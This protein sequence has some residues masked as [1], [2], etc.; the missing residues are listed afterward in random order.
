MSLYSC[1]SSEK[2]LR[3]GYWEHKPTRPEKSGGNADFQEAF[4]Q[5]EL[6]FLGFTKNTIPLL[7]G[8]PLGAGRAV[9][10][11]PPRRGAGA[12]HNTTL[13]GESASLSWNIPPRGWARVKG[14]GPLWPAASQEA[15][16]RHGFFPAPYFL[17][18]NVFNIDVSPWSSFHE[19]KSWF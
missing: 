7:G 14:W 18:K 12:R 5:P 15:P 2:F 11:R 9:G 19:G 4:S 8:P 16:S 17:F 10:P 1:Y 3:I 13:S 6:S